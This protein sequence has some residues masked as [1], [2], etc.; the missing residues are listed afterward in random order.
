M[1]KRYTIL[2]IIGLI[3]AMGVVGQADYDEEQRQTDQYCEMVAIW[4]ESGGQA[5]WPAYDG[6]EVCRDTQSNEKGAGGER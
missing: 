6:E 3:I 5:G 4:K 2:A 1:T